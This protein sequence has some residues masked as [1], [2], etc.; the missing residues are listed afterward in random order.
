MTHL[1]RLINRLH[2]G[3][4]TIIINTYHDDEVKVLYIVIKSKMNTFNYHL[5]LHY[6]A[7]KW[8]FFL[9]QCCYIFVVMAHNRRVFHFIEVVT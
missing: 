1:A 3:Q 4:H 2:A 6:L 8:L 7:E 5:G 9:Y